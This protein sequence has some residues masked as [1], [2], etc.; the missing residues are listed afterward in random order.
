MT[1]TDRPVDNGVNVFDV[2]TK[3][4]KVLVELA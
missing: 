3:P 4:V 1:A 2:V